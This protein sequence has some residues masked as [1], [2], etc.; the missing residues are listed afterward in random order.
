MQVNNIHLVPDAECWEGPEADPDVVA[1]ADMFLGKTREDV[2]PLLEANYVMRC[3]DLMGMP[4]CAFCYY[5]VG[6]A[7]FALQHHCDDENFGVILGALLD[8]LSSRWN[9]SPWLLRLMW[10]QAKPLFDELFE[11]LGSAEINTETKAELTQ[12]FDELR[13][14]ANGQQARGSGSGLEY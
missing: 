4:D 10:H 7:E 3:L 9:R 6:F 14:A 2:V 1:T 12:E 11:R 8:A 5:A 13:A